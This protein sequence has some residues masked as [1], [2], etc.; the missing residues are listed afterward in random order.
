MRTDSKPRVLIVDDMKS[1]LLN[2]K[3]ILT[4]KEDYQIAT[5]ENG[6]TAIKKAKAQKLDLILLDIVMPDI[7]GFDVCRELKR[8][9]QTK[10]I[11]VIFLTSKNDPE[12]IIEGFSCGA[13]DY[14][15]K[16]FVEEELLA[17][18]R[19]HIQLNRTKKQLMEARDKA[20][21]ATNAKSMF[22]ANMSHE[23]RTPMNG[24]VGMVEA[25]KHTQ[26]TEDQM[27]YLNIIDISS[28]NLLSVV[29]DIL[30]FSK[31]EAGQIELENITFNIHKVIDEVV[32]MLKFKADQK[33]LYLKFDVDNNIPA[34]IIGDSLRIKQ[35]LINLINNAIKF[36]SRGGITIHCKLESTDNNNITLRL[37]VVDTGIGISNKVKDKLFESFTQADASTTRKFGG[38]GLGLAISKS[39][40][41][42]MQGEIGVDSVDGE[43]SSFWFT[44]LLE[45]ASIKDIPQ[46]S[47]DEVIS[48]AMRQLDI[49]VAEDNSI[50]Q[51]VA[52]FII[53]K[54]GHKIEIAENGEIAVEKFKDGNYDIIFMDIQ[55]PVMDGI[56][57]TENIRKIEKSMEISYGVPIIA[58][59]ANTL[60]GDKEKFIESGM[61]DYIGKPF[62]AAELSDLI[63]KIIQ[64]KQ[65]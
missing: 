65:Q 53:E 36:T 33:D 50:N 11:P 3:S 54:L 56:V 7:S 25:L 10:D 39:L 46:E 12:S 5:A 34:F 51:R 63:F 44:V 24:V 48:K 38:T 61:N 62:K 14:V 49:L 42:L 6:K 40:T 28:E 37:I 29:N 64:T 55:M 52:R 13:V 59:T 21:L 57:A 35:I 1:N 19:V 8:M 15:H 18:A 4:S 32:K 31:V 41:K 20:E 30:D 58:M 45:K 17:R 43:G 16:P 60:K 9:P 23:I 26:L 47:S 2:M 22:L 27:E